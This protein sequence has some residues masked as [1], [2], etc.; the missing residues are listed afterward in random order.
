MVLELTQSHWTR[1][2]EGAMGEVEGTLPEEM[3][4]LEVWTAG[5]EATRGV[6]SGEDWSNLK[7]GCPKP[8]LRLMPEVS[9]LVSFLGGVGMLIVR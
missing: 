7:Q 9:L 3:K 4:G 6:C 5:L 8:V 1:E 2:V